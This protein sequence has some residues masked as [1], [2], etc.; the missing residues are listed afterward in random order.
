MFMNIISKR[1]PTTNRHCAIYRNTAETEAGRALGN[2]FQYM[3]EG[4]PDPMMQAII[5]NL[6]AIRKGI[7]KIDQDLNNF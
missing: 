2:V 5:T 1:Y 7:I 6:I 3:F 4:G